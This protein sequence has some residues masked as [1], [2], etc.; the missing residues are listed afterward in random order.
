MSY[1]RFAKSLSLHV[2][3]LSDEEKQVAYDKF[4]SKYPQNELSRLLEKWMK[5]LHESKRHLY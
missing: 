4:I 1:E 3:Q 5:E 2:E